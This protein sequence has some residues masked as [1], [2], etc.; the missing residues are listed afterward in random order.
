M[1]ATALSWVATKPLVGRAITH[2]VL[3]GSAA[4]AAAARQQS[5]SGASL[6][7]YFS[8]YL[9]R[10]LLEE[11]RPT[12]TPPTTSWFWALREHFITVDYPLLFRLGDALPPTA[13]S[14]L[15]AGLARVGEAALQGAASVVPMRRGDKNRNSS[16]IVRGLVEFN[17][18]RI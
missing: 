14:W 12:T 10:Y 8:P 4:F 18:H 2:R 11:Q 17:K 9:D 7:C 1:C 13:A 15:Y 16:S 6:F 3:R 5:A